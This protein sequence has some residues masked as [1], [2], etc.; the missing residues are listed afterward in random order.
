MK[1]IVVKLV[2]FIPKANAF[3]AE[4]VHGRGDAEKMFEKFG[5]DIFVSVIFARQLDRDAH[6]VERKH[7]HPAGAIALLE[8][9]A[10]GK[11]RVAIEDADVVES[12]ESA[13]ENIFTFG[14][15]PVHPPGEG[16]EHFVEDR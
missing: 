4:I 1:H 13:L 15:F 16:D 9:A 14:V 12:E 11:A 6:Q 7:S 5:S 10:V 2:F 3:A 8:M